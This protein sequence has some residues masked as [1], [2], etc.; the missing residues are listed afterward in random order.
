MTV[1]PTVPL[2]LAVVVLARDEEANIKECLQSA[3]WADSLHVILD[4]RSTDGTAALAERAGAEVIPQPFVNFAAQREAALEAVD[5]D[6]VFFVDA[7]ERAGPELGTECRGAI[8]DPDVVGWWVPRRNYM[9]GHWIRHAGW[10]PDHQLRLLRRG[11]AHYDPSREVH[12]VVVLDGSQGWLS[13][14]LVH[15]N[16]SSLTQFVAKQD[17]YAHYEA[18]ILAQEPAN[19]RP[20]RL[21]AGPIRE[22]WRRYVTLQGYR[23]GLDGLVLSALMGYFVGVAHWRAMNQLSQS[24]ESADR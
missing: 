17:Y 24:V 10:Y 8:Q 6:W 3:S 14:P 2:K 9:W 21:V 23:D 20:R 18:A 1:S 22:F 11:R 5:S 7:D 4:P 16:Y 19:L 12:E 15:Y 13:T